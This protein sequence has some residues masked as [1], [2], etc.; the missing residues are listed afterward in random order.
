MADKKVYRLEVTYTTN[1]GT[2]THHFQVLAE[3]KWEAIE[4]AVTRYRE[5]QPDRQYYKVLTSWSRETAHAIAFLSA[6]AFNYS[7]QYS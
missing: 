7:M 4:R 1:C 3:S 2:A 6:M 5:I